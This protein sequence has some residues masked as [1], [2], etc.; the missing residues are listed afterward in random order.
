MADE[1]TPQHDQLDVLNRSVRYT[2]WA[3]YARGAA[4]T[5][6]ASDGGLAAWADGLASDDVVLRGLYDVSGMRA[7]ADLMVWLHGPSAESLQAALRGFRRTAAGSTCTLAWSAMGT[8]RPAEFSRDHIPSFMQ[9]TQPL[10]WLCM[11]PF[12]RSYEWYLLPE[13]ER[14]AMLREHGIAGREFPDVQPNTVAA[15]ALNDYEWILALEA[16][17]L[18]DLVDMMRDLRATQARLHVREEIPFYTGRLVDN[19]GA[20]EVLR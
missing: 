8:H 11:Y 15:F 4:S 19:D 10:P 16:V 9:D 14:R 1:P 18:H 13:D 6:I 7:E 17:N 20:A 3:V 2:V 5:D 12:V